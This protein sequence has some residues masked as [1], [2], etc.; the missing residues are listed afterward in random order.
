MV[1]TPLISDAGFERVFSG[2]EAYV[3]TCDE[4]SCDEVH[5][6]G[7]VLTPAQRRRRKLKLLAPEELEEASRALARAKRRQRVR[8]PRRAAPQHP[9]R[10]VLASAALTGAVDGSSRCRV[11]R[12]GEGALRALARHCGG[13]L[14]R[15]DVD[16]APRVNDAALLALAATC[17][18]LRKLGVDGCSRVT[19]VGVAAVARNCALLERLRA[20]GCGGTTKPLTD[21]SGM[22]LGLLVF[23]KT[24]DLSRSRVG[25][26]G[27]LA[28]A[29]GCASLE[30]LR[31]VGCD[32][33]TDAGV[34]ALL[35]RCKRLH[36]LNLHGC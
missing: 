30:V 3:E 11:P 14:R 7:D 5:E 28:M 24:C 8:P 32:D 15:V 16:G 31:L 20:G 22:A 29:R 35:A 13:D 36:T 17:P 9:L 34:A 1:D 23:L 2:K 21:E 19:D 33:V 6:L 10:D 12:F 18:Q 26:E 4:D 27:L 25:V